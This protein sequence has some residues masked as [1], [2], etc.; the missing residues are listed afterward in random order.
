[1][2]LHY[3]V[4]VSLEEPHSLIRQNVNCHTYYRHTIHK[5]TPT[6]WHITWPLLTN[7]LLVLNLLNQSDCRAHANYD[8][9]AT[10]CR[11]C[12]K[13][14]WNRLMVLGIMDASWKKHCRYLVHSRAQ[15]LASETR[16]QTRFQFFALKCNRK[17]RFY[18]P[19]T[20][21]ASEFDHA[22]RILK[23]GELVYTVSRLSTCQG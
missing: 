7:A 11:H 16:F 8:E 19:C 22:N 4:D 13:N 14:D 20:S 21:A 23:V 2:Y 5:I 18:K 12:I 3:Y 15:V 9:D 1:M 6:C 17:V 10:E